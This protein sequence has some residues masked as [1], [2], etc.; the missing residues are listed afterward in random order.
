MS[1][2][3]LKY[4]LVAFTVL[5]SACKKQ[6]NDVHSP[7]AIRSTASS[8]NFKLD[9][10]NRM[11]KA[12]INFRYDRKYF[13]VDFDRIYDEDRNGSMQISNTDLMGETNDFAFLPAAATTFSFARRIPNSMEIIIDSFMGNDGQFVDETEIFKGFNRITLDI[14]SSTRTSV[15]LWSST[16]PALYEGNPS[17]VRALLKHFSGELNDSDST[18]PGNQ[19]LRFLVY[20]VKSE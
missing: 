12:Y 1:L 20:V 19:P 9:V 5:I 7:Q 17:A 10:D 3:K 13:S 18:Q 4:L 2:N 15:D 6:G 8:V 14:D 11:W 16:Y